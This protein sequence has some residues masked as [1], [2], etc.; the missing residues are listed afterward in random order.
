MA[1]Q[2]T[3]G[4]SVTSFT[5]TPQAQDDSYLYDENWLLN[6]LLY[7]TTTNTISLDVMSGDLGGGAKT[8]FSIDDGNGNPIPPDFELLCK[9]VNADGISCWERTEIGNWI[10][11][12]KGKVEYRIADGSGIPGQGVSV[13]SLAGGYALEDHFVYAIRLGGTYLPNVVE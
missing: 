5:N 2:A 6:S 7:N 1:T 9:D 12:N 10:R 13:D 8:L 4:G 11:I 3:G